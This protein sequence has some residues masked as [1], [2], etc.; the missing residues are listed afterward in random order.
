MRQK[1]ALAAL[2]AFHAGLGDVFRIPVPGF[3]PV[4]LVGAEA[5][6]F[7]LVEQTD[8]L[9]WRAERD[10]VT[11]LLRHGVLVEDGEAHDSLRR[12]MTPALHR[13]MVERYVEAMW[14][15]TDRV[16]NG[17]VG[18]TGPLDMLAQ[19]RQIALLILAR[20]LFDVDFGPD[21]ERLWR[22]ILRALAFI[23][24][25]P[26]LL[27]RAVPRPGYG[28][29]LATLD[30]YLRRII[31]ERRA[32]SRHGDDL[33]SLLIASGMSD[34]LIRDQLLT[35]I[36]AGHDTSTALLSWAL[37]AL[38]R[39]PQVQARAR[40]EVAAVLESRPP[41]VSR[42]GELRYLDQVIN[43][44]LRLYPPI[45]LGSRIAARELE[46]QGFR[47]PAGTRVLYSIYL[48][49]RDARYWDDP[50]AF[51]PER[52][53]ADRPGPYTFLPFGGGSRN[54]IGR[55]FAQAEARVVLAR[56]L[57]KFE[58]ELAGKEVRLH[59]GAT[60]EPRPGVCVYVQQHG[61]RGIG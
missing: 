27:W 3:K 42:L 58:L 48:T 61:Q 19:M 44:T 47:I 59:M 13:R 52:F 6:R 30:E 57:Q 37:Y 33:L 56:I 10:P 20:T 7:V 23:S 35:M 41:D 54:C 49:H 5:N 22:P 38:S 43:E 16:I 8:A 28:A 31:R 25:G 45:H 24:P 26:W 21:M 34:E 17:W 12:E 14:Q 2:E 4:M 36:I 18:A 9:R 53:G 60:L 39:Y 32:D 15:C 29:A 51:R 1:S 11:R 40:E 46:F 50:A 55:A